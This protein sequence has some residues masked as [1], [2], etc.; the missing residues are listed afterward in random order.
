MPPR[1]RS[2]LRGSHNGRSELS[3]VSDPT[4]PATLGQSVH[5][6]AAGRVSAAW[7]K[8]TAGLALPQL[9]SSFQWL[10]YRCFIAKVTESIPLFGDF[11]LANQIGTTEYSRPR[12]FRVTVEKRPGQHL[13]TMARMPRPD[14]RRMGSNCRERC[15]RSPSISESEGTSEQLGC[16]LRIEARSARSKL[17]SRAQLQSAW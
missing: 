10:S 1:R 4:Q 12:R 3:A 5:H 16:I 17:E 15:G 2:H 9:A 6:A 13:C 7:R 14:P 11:G 8:R